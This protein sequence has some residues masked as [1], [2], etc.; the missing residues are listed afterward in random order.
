MTNEINDKTKVSLGLLIGVVGAFSMGV[1]SL[2]RSSEAL[3]Y[4]RKD[5]DKATAVIERHEDRIDNL[6]RF[7]ERWEEWTKRIEPRIEEIHRVVVE[8][9]SPAVMPG[10]K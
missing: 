9:I 7:R 2:V 6:E 1:V 10:G 5:L 3:G 4:A 8:R